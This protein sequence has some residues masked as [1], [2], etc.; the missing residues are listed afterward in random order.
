MTE[1]TTVTVPSYITSTA[2]ST[3]TLASPGNGQNHS[4]SHIVIPIAFKP[5][6]LIKLERSIKWWDVHPPCL[7]GSWPNR[8]GETN[9]TLTFLCYGRL[10][11]GQ[12]SKLQDLYWSLN[13]QVCRCFQEMEIRTADLNEASDNHMKGSRAMFESITSGEIGLKNPQYVF[14]MEPDAVPI[15]PDWLNALDRTCRTDEKFWVKGSALRHDL[16]WQ[17]LSQRY[18][19]SF[20]YHI[21]GNAIYN[22]AAGEYPKFYHR[23]LIPYLE[24]KGKRHFHFDSAL[25]FYLQDIH[26][27]DYW[28][29]ISHHF[30]YTDLIQNRWGENYS[31]PER[32]SKYPNTYIIHGGVPQ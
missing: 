26:N 19:Q 22:M 1:T 4:L 13:W 12:R 16:N 14:W 6:Q 24:A 9:T 25:A 17:V 15:R 10:T 18:G 11:A 29:Q 30:Q 8:P 20:L 5:S 32:A 23:I 7:E 3:V 2:Y 21:N 31:V 27:V 28:R